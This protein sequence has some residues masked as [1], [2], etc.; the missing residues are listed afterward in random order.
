LSQLT[1]EKA[2]PGP[3]RDTKFDTERQAYTK[4]VVDALE[5]DK[6][7]DLSSATIQ[8]VR[9]TITALYRRV[10]ETIPATKQPDHLEAMNYL[11]GLAGFSKML[12]KPNVEQVLAE[13]SKIDQTTVGN[14]IAF[15]HSYNLRFGSADTPVQRNAYRQ[16]Y[17]IMV[18]TSE[19][20]IGKPSATNAANV[21]GSP[22]A[23]APP[24]GSATSGSRSPAQIFHGMDPKFLYPAPNSNRIPNPPTGETSPKVSGGSR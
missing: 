12:E 16:L 21:Q 14:L 15:M 23:P 10:G 8:R 13:L 9:E 3:L 7:G 2:W 5:E 11:K 4:A 1:D 19:K 6:N 24:A 17:P 18:S 22:A 20:L